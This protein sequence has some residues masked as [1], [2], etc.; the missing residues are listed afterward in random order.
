MQPGGGGGNVQG[1]GRRAFQQVGLNG[2]NQNP[3]EGGTDD[4]TIAEAGAQLGQAAS[5]DAVQMIGTV[6]MGQTPAGGFPQPGD[7][8]PNGLGGFGNGDNTIPGQ[9]APA[10]FAGGGP[11]GLGG[12]GP[13]PGPGVFIQR[14]GGGGGRGRGPQGGP[15][16]VDAL[17][18]AQ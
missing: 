2:Q 5:A 10:G 15:Q 9:S 13:G 12:G 8:G 7:G 18:G 1:G 11:G 17:W 3:G 6:A 4:Q 14:G 16:G